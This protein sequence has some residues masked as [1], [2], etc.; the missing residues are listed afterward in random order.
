MVQSN[1][2]ESQPFALRGWGVR[3]WNNYDLF[4]AEVRKAARE[5]GRYHINLLDLHDGTVPPGIGWVELFAQYRHVQALRD[6]SSLTYKGTVIPERDRE[7][8][9]QKFRDLCAYV[10][11]Q[12]LR[13]HVWYHVLRDL[14]EEWLI[15]EP[16]ISR[17]EGRR[18]WQVI[19]SMLEDLFTGVPEID[20]LVVTAGGTTAYP[21]RDQSSVTPGERLRAVYQCVYEACRRH[22]KQFIIRETGDT[23]SESDT[24]LYAIGPLPPEIQ[25]MVKNVQKDWCH[26]TAPVNPTLQRLGGKTVLLETD[27][28]GEHWGRSAL[29]LARPGYVFELVRSW[30]PLKAAGAVGRIMVQEEEDGVE[31]SI[32]SSPGTVNL[33]AFGKVLAAPGT[34]F[35]Q[36]GTWLPEFDELDRSLWYEWAAQFGNKNGNVS[37]CLVSALE[38]SPLICLYTLYLAGAYFQDRS[39]FPGIETFEKSIWPTFVRKSKHVD[40]DVLVWEKDEAVRIAERSLEDLQRAAP[41]MDPQAVEV[42][43]QF[44]EHA[45]DI[46]AAFRSL[47]ELCAGRVKPE[48]LR[49]TCRDANDLAT[50]IEI[51]RG[52]GFYGRLPERLR[53]LSA[54][55]Q[56]HTTERSERAD[57]APPAEQEPTGP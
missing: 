54:Y 47:V 36:A 12:G 30:L 20:A 31:T 27:L 26:L 8:Y 21:T 2:A 38:T 37:P 19:G 24:F 44:F 46:A 56:D 1:P 22:R 29:P 13:I 34:T 45:K 3:V 41:T 40:L 39:F 15:A 25:I 49:T 4:D 16:T 28:Y 57:D 5:A 50:R 23:P 9:R 52:P 35:Q 42:F 7:M 17:L 51:L 53:E 48:T 32:F 33:H 18:L 55:V 6:K 14:P 43:T 10:K 11:S